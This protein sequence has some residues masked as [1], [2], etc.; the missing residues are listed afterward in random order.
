MWKPFINRLVA[1]NPEIASNPISRWKQ[2]QEIKKQ[3]Y[4]AKAAQG[5]P[6]VLALPVVVAKGTE[7]TAQGAKTLSWNGSKNL[8]SGIPM[9]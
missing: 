7:K 3:Y 2:R 1:D 9:P 4:A 5:L 6:L 8:L